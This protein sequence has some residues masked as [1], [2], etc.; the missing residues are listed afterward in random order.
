MIA[1]ILKE[2]ERQ[3]CGLVVYPGV[4]IEERRRREPCQRPVVAAKENSKEYLIDLGA[5]L[6]V[7]GAK[8][9]MICIVVD[10]P[11]ACGVPL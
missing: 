3:A 6:E 4:A 8:S 7:V 10:N 11:K 2:L 1:V 9:R 5:Y